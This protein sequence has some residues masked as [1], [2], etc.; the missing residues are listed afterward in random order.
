M[1][2]LTIKKNQYKKIGK[3]IEILFLNQLTNETKIG[4]KA[5]SDLPIK[6]KKIVLQN[7]KKDSK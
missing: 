6:R 3:E 7:F 4:I 5:P 1:L 2:V